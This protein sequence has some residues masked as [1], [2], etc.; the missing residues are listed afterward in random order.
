MNI[1]EWWP[2]LDQSAR[3]WLVAHNGEVVPE[4]VLDQIIAVA[5]APTVGATWVG[6]ISDD[7]QDDVEGFLLSDDAVDWIE[8]FANGED[9]EAQTPLGHS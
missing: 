8:Q 3:E 1:A 2:H 6:G 4:K 7:D 9:A 5:G